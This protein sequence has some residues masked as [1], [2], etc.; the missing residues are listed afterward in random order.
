[1]TIAS[2]K[3][4]SP[5]RRK[6]LVQL[7]SAAF[8]IGVLAGTYYDGKGLFLSIVCIA[9][10]FVLTKRWRLVSLVLV[11]ACTLGI[12]RINAEPRTPEPNDIGSFALPRDHSQTVEV[13]GH[14]ARFPDYRFDREKWVLAADRII[15]A[16]GETKT[17]D[18]KVLFQI[19]HGSGLRF[20]EVITLSGKLE[21]PFETEEF[22]YKNYLAR[23]QIF[24]IMNYPQVE[25]NGGSV[26]HPLLSPLF[27]LRSWFDDA[28]KRAIPS[29]ESAFA[30]G[31]L[32]GDRSGFT[33]EYEEAFRKTG[34]SHLLALS[35]YNITIIVLAV[36][37]LLQWF[38]KPIRLTMTLGFLVFFVLF[39]GGGASIVRAA[40][41]GAIGLFVVHS[42]RTAHGITLLLL[43]SI[44]MV[45][46]S[47]LIL[48]FDPSFQLSFAGVVGLLGFSKP[49]TE[50]FG[51]FIKSRFWRELLTATLAAQL[52]VMPLLLS[53]FGEISLIAPLANLI[54]APLVPIEM[55]LSFLAVIPGSLL[56]VVGTI[57]AFIAWN[58]LHVSLLLIKLL[59]AIPGA[60]INLQTEVLGML[61][62]LAIIWLPLLFWQYK[63]T[64]IQK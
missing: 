62:T 29:P 23:E 40:V 41:M 7:A 4:V 28:L 5:L 42:G 37:W 22:S 26:I 60:S 59:A 49:L 48:A 51:R 11:L 43:A 61:L 20:G 52:G 14:I 50:I 12:A 32:I 63:A 16:N 47:P 15:L 1:M 44:A 34:L 8:L 13:S 55:L 21:I 25:K 57:I 38:T 39:V 10:P 64:V 6:H 31:I 30:A 19:R 54:I 45:L 9:L 58:L 53:L 2:Q 46:V 35:G 24:A 56:G 33:P 27:A 36:F 18:G 3:N 17:V